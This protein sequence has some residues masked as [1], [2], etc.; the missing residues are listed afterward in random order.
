MV[1]HTIPSRAPVLVSHREQTSEESKDDQTFPTT[2]E[3]QKANDFPA[4]KPARKTERSYFN[5]GSCRTRGGLTGA[6]SSAATTSS[7][8][9]EGIG[10]APNT[11]IGY[12]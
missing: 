5:K 9:T 4:S 1:S 11:R 10:P 6:A 3:S 8:K 12:F 7:A 2:N